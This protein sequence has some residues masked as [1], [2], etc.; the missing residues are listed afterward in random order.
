MISDPRQY[1]IDYPH[2]NI[3][4]NQAQ[5]VLDGKL[6]SEDLALVFKE[7][8]KNEK[9]ALINVAL[10][11]APSLELT[12]LIWDKLNTAI[13]IPNNINYA[14]IFAIP[15]VL[16]AGS[17]SKTKLNSNI[18]GDVLNEFMLDRQIFRPGA[19]IFISGKLID[20]QNISSLKFSQLYYWVRNLQKAR[21]WLPIELSGNA[22]EVLNDGVFL[23]F[24]IG[25]SI[26]NLTESGLN[27]QAFTQNSMDLMKLV[28]AQLKNDAVTLF[29]IPFA[30]LPLS[31]ALIAGNRYRT[32]IA[33]SVAISNI[34]RKIREQQQIPL[35][36]IST[37]NDAIR[38]MINSE[39]S[40]EL[41]E[42]SLWHLNRV[43]GFDQTLT[44]ITNLLD[45]MKIEWKYA[46]VN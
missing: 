32:E 30:P 12:K 46:L 27:Q 14:N 1:T 13:N 29:S 2:T 5:M 44:M 15:L 17:K 42:E 43:D 38:I 28:N 36:T 26:D 23:R 8:L 39:T 20:P 9:D 25:V 37:I 24:L 16:V 41:F 31:E 18:D 45:D 3:I 10:N 4:I 35:A 22:I 34:A 7:I 6:N 19:D 33:I 21:L 11:L 40:S